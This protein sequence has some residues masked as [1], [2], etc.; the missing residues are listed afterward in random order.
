MR[1]REQRLLQEFG[2][3][4]GLQIVEADRA[5]FRRALAPFYAS[6]QAPWEHGTLDA[7]EAL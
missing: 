4:D 6:L 7:M 3:L 5:A 2:R 1:E